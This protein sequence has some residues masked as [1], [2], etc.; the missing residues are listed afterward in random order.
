[1]KTVSRQQAERAIVS[2]FRSLVGDSAFRSGTRH[3]D[4]LLTWE[5]NL[6]PGVE[7]EL[8]CGALSLGSGGELIEKHGGAPAKFCA[9]YSSSALCVNSFGVA[10]SEPALLAIFGL[11]GFTTCGF[12]EKLPTGLGGTPPNLDLVAASPDVRLAVES[13]FLEPLSRKA[14]KFVASYAAAYKHCGDAALNQAYLAIS[15][16]RERFIYLD[17]AQLLK[18]ALGILKAPQPPERNVFAYLFWEPTNSQELEPFETHRR[19][20]ATFSA[21]MEGS[22]IQ[23]RH[24]S[25][26]NLWRSWQSDQCPEK[27]RQHVSCLIERYELEL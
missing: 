4:H 23:F 18:H 24:L 1:M 7:P 5:L 13:K 21:L 3:D 9:P 8:V 22:Q 6:V 25:Y 15:S 12:E 20:I 27:L 26:P 11:S 2:Q 14:P 16:G 17:V 10:R 19:E